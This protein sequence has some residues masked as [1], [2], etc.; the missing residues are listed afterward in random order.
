ML[1]G[2]SNIGNF[3]TGDFGAENQRKSGKLAKKTVF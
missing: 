2:T 3:F 1:F